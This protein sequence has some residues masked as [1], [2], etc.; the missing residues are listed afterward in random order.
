MPSKHVPAEESRATVLV[1]MGRSCEGAQGICVVGTI[2]VAL[3]LGVCALTCVRGET[4]PVALLGDA[5]RCLIWAVSLILGARYFRRAGKDGGPF[6]AGR[7]REL[8]VIS[9]LVI[10]SS[11]APGLVS[12]LAQKALLAT[13]ALPALTQ[14]AAAFESM[15]IVD[16]PLLYAG[17]IIEAFAMIISY[18]CLLQQQDDG[19]V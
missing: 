6:R 14:G 11:F 12:W 4:T 5:V 2:I 16:F 13:G 8:K 10:L 3:N 9:K 1:E 18:G 15:T 7:T 19:L 17:L